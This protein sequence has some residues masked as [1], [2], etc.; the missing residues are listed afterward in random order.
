MPKKTVKKPAQNS[1][2]L[3]C[4]RTPTKLCSKFAGGEGYTGY[5]AHYPENAPFRGNCHPD[6]TEQEKGCST[7]FCIYPGMVVSQSSDVL[8]TTGWSE[9]CSYTLGSFCF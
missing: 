8:L 2:N 3:R 4:G 1:Q 6:L 7:L 5:R 9:S